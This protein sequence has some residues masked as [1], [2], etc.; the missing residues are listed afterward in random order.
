MRTPTGA[1]LTVP[2]HQAGAVMSP[3]AEVAWMFT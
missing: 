3:R 2:V 1:E